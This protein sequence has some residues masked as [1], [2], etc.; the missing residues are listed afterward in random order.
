MHEVEVLLLERMHVTESKWPPQVIY[1]VIYNQV[2]KV[3][4]F[5]QAVDFKQMVNKFINKLLFQENM[6]RAEQDSDIY[7]DM[8]M[9][10]FYARHYALSWENKGNKN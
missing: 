8:W 6:S 1:T 3:N 4:C 10:L 5:L 9:C 7:S 2:L